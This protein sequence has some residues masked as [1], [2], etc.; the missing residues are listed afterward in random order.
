MEASKNLVEE[1]TLLHQQNAKLLAELQKYKIKNPENTDTPPADSTPTSQPFSVC[2]VA[3]K[4][5]P[6]WPDRPAIWFAQVEAQFI[7]SGISADLTKFNYVVAQLDTRVIGEVEDIILRP[8]LEDKYI[9]LK[10]ELIRRLSTSEEQQVRKL[11]FPPS[12]YVT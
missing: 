4:L 5:P 3:V 7:I 12:F 11:V 2:K 1:N 10:Y 6:F 8:P 9:R